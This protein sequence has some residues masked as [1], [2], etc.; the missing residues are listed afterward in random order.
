MRIAISCV[1]G[2]TWLYTWHMAAAFRETRRAEI[3]SDLWECGREAD[4]M[5]G[6]GSA[7]HMLLRLLLGMPDDV[8]WRVEHAAGGDALT[9]GGVAL[10][11][12]V[13]GAALFLCALWVIDVDASRKRP[14]PAVSL[15]P[16]GATQPQS[17]DVGGPAFDVAS[18]KPNVSGDLRVSIQ[19][20]SGGRFTAVNAPL[21][22]LI[23]HAYQLQDFELTGGPK[24]IESERVDI[25]AKAE[26]EATPAQLRLMLRNLL[27]DRFKLQLRTETRDLP[28]YALVTARRN[29]RI[30][31]DLRRTESDCSQSA[32]IQDTLGI[33]ARSGPPDPDATCG[34]FGPGP[35][36]CKVSRRDHRSTCEV[37]SAARASSGVRS[38]GPNGL[39]RR[40]PRSDRGVWT[41][42]ASSR[43]V[44]SNRSRNAPLDLQRASG[45]H[46]TQTRR[47]AWAGEGI[48]DRSAG[49]LGG[50]LVG[51]TSIQRHLPCGEQSLAALPSADTIDSP[52]RLPVQ[53]RAQG[54]GAVR[55]R[56]RVARSLL[57]AKGLL[58]CPGG[59]E[60]PSASPRVIR[61]V[62]AGECD[63]P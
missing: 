20:S 15:A 21:R 47:S 16:Q 61:E 59:S 60:V 43:S 42:A 32:S 36:E 49:A 14:A 46:G 9:Q 13:A 38:N 52:L 41:A 55:S 10:T 33:T 4:A 45:P 62:S 56:G 39:L 8:G 29:A 5:H 24:W 12:R 50:S 48:C 18:I 54:P 26:G 28:F 31:P 40:G 44:R 23:R 1:R 11:A 6:V 30:G 51:A 34:F 17:S 37:P 63:S 53:R 19:A 57:V 35:G 3:E 25:V 2:W 27:T 7:L 22:A 58:S